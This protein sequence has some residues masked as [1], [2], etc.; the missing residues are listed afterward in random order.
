M[1]ITLPYLEFTLENPTKYFTFSIRIC[2]LVLHF[3]GFTLHLH[4]TIL[5]KGHLNLKP[6]L[7]GYILL[8]YILLLFRKPF[9]KTY[10]YP[11]G[12]LSSN[13][14]RSFTADLSFQC[15]LKLFIHRD[16]TVGF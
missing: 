2:T 1:S 13:V 11:V 15:S 16:T 6:S 8:G 4:K 9:L 5:Y 12:D 10:N 14:R 3:L 7:L